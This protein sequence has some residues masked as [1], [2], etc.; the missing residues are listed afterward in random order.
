MTYTLTPLSIKIKDEN[1][2]IEVGHGS[3]FPSPVKANWR[4]YVLSGAIYEQ[5]GAGEVDNTGVNVKY[6]AGDVKIIRYKK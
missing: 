3:Y 2:Y 5:M 1:G 4:D 6:E